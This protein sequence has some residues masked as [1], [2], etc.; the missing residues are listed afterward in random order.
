MT[1]DAG[2]VA[3]DGLGP[4]TYDSTGRTSAPDPREWE[5]SRDASGA[6]IPGR[7]DYGSDH[8]SDL[9]MIVEED[10]CS[11]GRGC[12]KAGTLAQRAEFGDGGVCPHILAVI[13]GDPVPELDPL[14]EG[15]VCRAYEERPPPVARG[16]RRPPGQGDLFEVGR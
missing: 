12:V 6:W 9:I 2:F 15:P 7:G 3:W 4:D 11:R 5:F 16:K 13:L 10:N 8:C 1:S 14:P